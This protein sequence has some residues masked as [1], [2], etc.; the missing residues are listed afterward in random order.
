MR[1]WKTRVFVGSKN[2]V[3]LFSSRQLHTPTNILLLSLAV[4]DLLVGLLVMPVEALQ[5]T[6]CWFFGD[7]LCS[8]FRF[9]SYIILAASVVNMVLISFD[10][11]VAICDPLHYT[12]RITVNR[13][14]VCVCLLWFCSVA[15]NGFYLT[16]HL[17]QQEVTDESCYGECPTVINNTG[18]DL[19][20][21]LNFI[22]PVTT[23]IVLYTRVFVVAVSQARAMRSHITAVTKQIS[24]TKIAKKSE[25]KAARTLGVLVVVFLVCFMPTYFTTLGGSDYMSLSTLYFILYLYYFNSCLNPVIYALF[26]P[27]FRKSVKLIVTLQI[28][29]PGSCEANIL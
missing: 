9:V 27:W 28:L 23:I 10:R 15:Y 5:R 21:V 18:A 7:L 16:S 1:E 26:Y 19:Q 29:Q 12:T 24:V 2:D 6:E 11:Y 22:V 13:V 20:L 3:F 8:L 4:S 14:K 25:L 17:N